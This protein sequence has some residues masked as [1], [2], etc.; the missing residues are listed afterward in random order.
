MKFLFKIE[1]HWKI[2]DLR[3]LDKYLLQIFN[4]NGSM[5][6]HVHKGEVLGDSTPPP[7]SRSQFMLCQHIML[8]FSSPERFRGNK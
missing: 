8:T 2:S 1:I 3:L 6:K 5:V 7:P 4:E